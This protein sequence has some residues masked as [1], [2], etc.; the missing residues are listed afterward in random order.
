MK[1]GKK[2]V[3]IARGWRMASIMCRGDGSRGS[4]SIYFAWPESRAGSV[5]LSTQ[6]MDNSNEQSGPEKYHLLEQ[7]GSAD[8][9]YQTPS[10]I[11]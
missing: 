5:L 2:S 11:I 9:S 6:S 1:D 10:S 8:P 7:T 3:R 4:K